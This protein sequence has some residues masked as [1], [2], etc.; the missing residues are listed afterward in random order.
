[1][2]DVKKLSQHPKADEREK[3]SFA[4]MRFEDGSR[5]YYCKE[6]G[7][8]FGDGQHMEFTQKRS[9]QAAV[10]DHKDAEWFFYWLMAHADWQYSDALDAFTQFLKARSSLTTKDLAEWTLGEGQKFVSGDMRKR[11]EY[12]LSEWIAVNFPETVRELEAL[13][14]AGLIPVG[15][16][17]D[18]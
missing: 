6:N 17:I 16:G 5:G 13:Q 9:F 18:G 3:R 11:F 15:E 8:W 12:S 4:P 10:I 14:Q 2:D 1:M 7:C